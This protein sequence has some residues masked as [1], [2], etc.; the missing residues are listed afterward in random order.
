MAKFTV[1]THLFRELGELLVGRDSTALA[2]LIKNAYDA[3]ATL[4]T[5]YG[6]GLD[7]PGK[8]LIVVTDDGLGMRRDQFESGFL[9]VASRFKEQG[10]RR[11]LRYGR[12][13]TGAKGIGRL[14]AHKLAHVLDVISVPADELLVEGKPGSLSPVTARIDW[15]A[16]EELET[17]DQVEGSGAIVVKTASRP[18]TDSIKSGTIITLSK[19]RRKWTERDRAHFLSEVSG[20]EPPSVLV[21][22][23]SNAPANDL[24]LK[25]PKVRDESTGRPSSF[26]IDLTGD[27]DAGEAYWKALAEAADWI[28]EVDAS[29]SEPS[30]PADGFD[31]EAEEPKPGDDRYAVPKVAVKVIPT[32]KTRMQLNVVAREFLIDHPYP[33]E[34]PFFQA[35]I[36]S[37]V[38][39]PPSTVN[40]RW[41]DEASGIRVFMEGFRVLPYG[42]P[43]DDWLDLDADYAQRSTS[44]AL[45]GGFGFSVEAPK[46]P[47]R[48]LIQPGRQYFGGVFCT[49][50]NASELTMLINREGFLPNKSYFALKDMVRAAIDLGTRVRALA[51]EETAMKRSEKRDQAAAERD[52]ARREAEERKAL[53]EQ[54][55]EGLDRATSLATEARRH[56]ARG[57]YQAAGDTVEQVNQEVRQSVEKAL[58]LQSEGSTLRVLASVGLQLTTFVHEINALRNAS[59]DLV[60][61]AERLV[62]NASLPPDARQDASFLR[63]RLADFTR[64]LDRQAAY[65][66]DVTSADA[67]RRR[68]RQKIGERLD[69]AAR[70][71]APA[72]VARRIALE[73]EVP[74]SA[75]TPPMFQ[76]EITVVLTNLLTNAI[77]AAGEGGRIR[78]HGEIWDDGTAL[79]RLENT[80]ASVDVD[81]SERLFRAFESTT[82]SVDPV[83][84]QGMGMGL[85]ITRNLLGEYGASIRFV[86]PSEGFATAIEVRF[87]R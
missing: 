27:F 26:S 44:A 14:A 53:K 39:P 60:E 30:E 55:E 19:L 61:A 79:L 46:D 7:N 37:R 25:K 82:V 73:N 33:E 83:L 29:R 58:Q 48:V 34:G 17:L 9:R 59:R 86:P 42:S 68:S 45:L 18:A 63:R 23:P 76:S 4:V 6:E 71:V 74:G 11:S 77:K 3:D 8:G 32:T 20:F 47:T 31:G 2:E 51:T 56:A 85:P 35:R 87:K 67:R 78:A 54:V 13:Y 49:V 84:G 52:R 16:I 43:G 80:G 15:D 24:L 66:I 21:D 5:V 36:F 75:E 72:M 28:I 38:G 12:R 62:S 1:D 69:A 40:K 64:D 70:V 65:L 41:L 81:D 10:E 57:D 50:A 22:P